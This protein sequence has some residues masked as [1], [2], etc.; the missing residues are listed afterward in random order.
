VIHATRVS[1]ARAEASKGK[2][3]LRPCLLDRVGLGFGS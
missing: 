2:R 3:D 1:I